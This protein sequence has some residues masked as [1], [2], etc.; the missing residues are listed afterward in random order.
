MRYLAALIALL[1]IACATPAHRPS[2]KPPAKAPTAGTPAETQTV[3]HEVERIVRS[4]Y[5]GDIDFVMHSTYPSVIALMGGPDVAR[6]SLETI[7]D[8]VRKS[9]MTLE[10]FAF[11]EPPEF[12]TA[13]G[14][15]FVFVPTLSV[16]AVNGK[17]FESRNFQLG[18]LEAGAT[19]WTYVEGSRL[20]PQNVHQLLPAFP[21]DRSFPPV[22]RKAL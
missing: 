5:S 14:T 11:P 21:S 18:V 9:G 17:R 3:Q 12:F 6:K 22:H 16:V 20:N 7:V 1:C 4:L 19:R 8:R 15:R 10:S 2:A 13:G